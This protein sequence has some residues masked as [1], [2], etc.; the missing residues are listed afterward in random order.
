[1]ANFG[2]EANWQLIYDQITYA[3]GVDGNPLA[4]RP[5][6]PITL[7][8]SL[9]YPFIRVAANYENAKSSWRLGSWIEFLVDES[10]PEV[11]VLRVL[12][13]VNKPIIIPKPSFL[14]SYKI[15]AIVPYYFE[16]ISLKIDGFTGVIDQ[17][18]TTYLLGV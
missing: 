6:L 3:Q 16:E 9:Q 11:E 10:N 18:P 5:I 12:A 15:R 7:P 8:F 14:G 13:P 2:D 4:Y 1:M 17:S